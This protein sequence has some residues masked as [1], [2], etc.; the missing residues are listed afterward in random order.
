MVACVRASVA[1]NNT[2]I[3]GILALR[4]LVNAVDGWLGYIIVEAQ[5]VTVT[6]N[7]APYAVGCCLL[8]MTLKGPRA[9]FARDGFKLLHESGRRAKLPILLMLSSF[10]FT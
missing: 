3:D 4:C 10:C 5:A 1:Q 7:V 6:Q 8:L 9:N 2:L